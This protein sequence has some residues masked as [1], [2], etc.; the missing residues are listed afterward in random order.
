MNGNIHAK[1]TSYMRMTQEISFTD[2]SEGI[3]ELLGNV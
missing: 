2:V 1:I 3:Q